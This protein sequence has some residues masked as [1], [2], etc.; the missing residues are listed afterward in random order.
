M[1]HSTGL[2]VLA[3]IFAVGLLFLIAG[4]QWQEARELSATA[5]V[6]GGIVALGFWRLRPRRDAFEAEANR[7]GLRHS[8]K[9]PFGLLDEPFDLWGSS[10][11][12][13]GTLDNVL[14]GTWRGLQVRA[15]EYEYSA[16]E[17]DR[18]EFSCAMVAIPGGWPALAIRPE[19][20]ASRLADVAVPEVAFESEA[21][22]RAFS[23]RCDDRRFASAFVDARMMA[24]LLALEPRW[25]FE[26]DGPWIL[27][28][29]DRVRPWEIE[30]VLETVAT[31][32]ERIPRVVGSLFP[33]TLPPRPD[34]VR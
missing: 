18:C 8:A 15:F 31:F 16:G 10:Q 26:I 20:L 28:Y 17:D 2:K 30:G 34:I 9:D 29:R 12:S 24:W 33:Q 6:V 5:L 27:G 19:S 21:F 7:L 14:W 13:F 22:D 4:R 32:V 1:R 3:G 11:R 25:G 23:V